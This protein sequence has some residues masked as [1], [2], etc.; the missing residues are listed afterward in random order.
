MSDHPYLVLRDI[1]VP[2]YLHF[3]T[4]GGSSAGCVVTQAALRQKSIFIKVLGGHKARV[5]LNG[6]MFGS[7]VSFFSFLCKTAAWVEYTV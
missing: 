7:P 6:G 5:R 4:C 3:E 2:S 1:E